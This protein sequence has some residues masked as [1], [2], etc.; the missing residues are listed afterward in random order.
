MWGAYFFILWS[1]WQSRK[2]PRM[3]SVIAAITHARTHTQQ[4]GVG[5]GLRQAPTMTD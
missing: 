1:T 3:K 2:C 5:P 4:I